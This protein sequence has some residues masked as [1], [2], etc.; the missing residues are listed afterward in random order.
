MEKKFIVKNGMI[1]A[2]FTEKDI[3]SVIKE[4]SNGITTNLND[5]K[6]TYVGSTARNEFLNELIVLLN[7]Q[8][9][10]SM[11]KIYNPFESM[12]FKED[13]EYGDLERFIQVLDARVS[14]YSDVMELNDHYK[15]E[16]I[17]QVIETTIRYRFDLSISES[18]MKNAFLSI[19]DFNNFLSEYFTS[20]LI[21][22]RIILLELITDLMQTTPTI[23]K[24]DMKLDGKEK[25]KWISLLILKLQQ[26]NTWANPWGLKTSNK[27]NELV[28]VMSNKLVNEI[29]W[30]AVGTML[31]Y[32]G[33]KGGLKDVTIIPWDFTD[34]ETH[35]W[36]GD[37]NM[38]FWI[39]T[40]LNKQ[41]TDAF[42]RT[43]IA[44]MYEHLWLRI[45]R[46]LGAQSLRVVDASATI[47]DGDVI[48]ALKSPITTQFKDYI[49]YES[50]DVLT[51]VD[52][53]DKIDKEFRDKI[54]TNENINLKI[55]NNK[56]VFKEIP[57]DDTLF[58]LIQEYNPF[59]DSNVQSKCSVV[60]IT[61][62]TF[63]IAV[64]KPY[65]VNSETNEITYK[66]KVSTTIKKALKEQHKQ[67]TEMGV[68][69]K[70]EAMNQQIKEMQTLHEKELKDMKDN[71]E[72][73]IKK[74][75]DRDERNIVENEKSNEFETNKGN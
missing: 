31:N 29:Q 19:S 17:D 15:P 33:M 36:I 22:K 21:S 24:L 38:A 39:D 54:Y 61:D 59:F 58:K 53:T 40:R 45:G 65:V 68:S 67:L 63:T 74:Y 55:R 4:A 71:Y 42:A 75:L 72:N 11:M 10:V 26:V 9:V 62:S 70:L 12:W 64:E 37:K 5:A 30:D 41:G 48:D 35:V 51:V 43:L 13:W 27:A 20:S 57:K 32:A 2:Q 3:N 46:I 56:F 6:T 28:I 73:I 34:G 47:K 16:V 69:N 25:A 18:T 49:K 44:D 52:V 50:T 66:Y 8:I 1:K 60:D 7:R 23:A 14:Q